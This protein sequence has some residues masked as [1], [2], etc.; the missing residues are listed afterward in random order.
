MNQTVF[1]SEQAGLSRQVPNVRTRF[2]VVKV[3]NLGNGR[4]CYPIILKLRGGITVTFPSK[5][6]NSKVSDP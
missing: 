2:A 6:D 5:R 1:G 4:I 3:M